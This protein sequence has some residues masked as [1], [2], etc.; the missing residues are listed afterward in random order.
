MKY[1]IFSYTYENASYS[2]KRCFGTDG[3][4]A[5]DLKT[6]FVTFLADCEKW[7]FGAINIHH[8][9]SESL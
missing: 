9:I 5:V 4:E 2:G 8:V 7:S 1:Y 3:Y 6:A